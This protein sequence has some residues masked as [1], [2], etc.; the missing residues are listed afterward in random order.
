MTQTSAQ[1]RP[2][3][4]EP[5]PKPRKAEQTKARI[6]DAALDLFLENGFE[7]T[8][9]RAIAAAADVSV[10]NAYYYFASKEH[11][12][13]EYYVRIQD[14][15]LAAARPVLDAEGGFQQRLRGVVRAHIDICA[16][17]HQFAGVLFKTAAD[18]RSPLSPFSGESSDTRQRSIALFTEL[19]E[20]SDAKAGRDLRAELPEL[21]WLYQMGIVLFWVHDDS[22][23]TK[24]TYL[25]IDRTVPLVDKLISVA[26]L[27]VLRPVTRQVIQTIHDLRGI[28]AA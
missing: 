2:E 13:Q 16:P 7:G 5:E 3:D 6:V 17:Y 25:L 12:I 10:G 18:P 14:L 21:L 20:G 4:E 9:M 23:R 11:L 28:P 1:P 8:T 19:F 22:T 27:P 24:R 26:R 15:H